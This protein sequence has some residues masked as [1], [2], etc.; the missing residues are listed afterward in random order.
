MIM[1]FFHP[2]YTCIYIRT[3]YLRTYMRIEA[4]KCCSTPHSN[5]WLLGVGKDEGLSFISATLHQCYPILNLPPSYVQYTYDI[6]FHPPPT[7]RL[8]NSL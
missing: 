4:T 7:S 5:Q 2:Q 1:I 3:L 6:R 8:W